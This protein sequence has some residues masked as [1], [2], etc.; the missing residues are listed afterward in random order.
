MTAIRKLQN[1]RFN[2]E[3]QSYGS[4][5][6]PLLYLHG[7]GGLMPSEPFLE[8]LGRDYR[9]VAPHLPGFGESTG[10]EHIDDV[11]DAVLFYQEL[12]DDLGIAQT[13]V[14]G[15]SLGGMLAA[16]LAAQN[17][18]RVKKL[19]LVAP[20]G[21]WLDAHPIPDVFAAQL[22][23]MAG[24]LFHDPNSPAAKLMTA[25]PEDFKLLEAMYVERVKR[26]AIASK[27]LWPVPDRGLNKRAYR[28]SAPTLMVWGES[29]R[30]IPPVYAKE[31]TSRIKNS[32][33]ATI[34]Q[35]GHLLMYEQQAAV[36]KAI[37]EFLKN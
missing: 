6:E 2:V 8:D 12:L 10:G 7:A 13:H 36:V 14:L 16:E 17:P 33:V 15:H 26:L 22:D 4:G 27:F 37:R 21:F 35:A 25:I 5:G 3:L 31:F 20:A 34:K 18:Q 28:I 1:G 23:E 29:D 24:L 11:V 32:R 9:I 19:V 30:L